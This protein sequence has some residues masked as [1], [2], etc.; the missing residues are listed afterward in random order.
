MKIEK[1]IN[2]TVATTVPT[3]PKIKRRQLVEWEKQRQIYEFTYYN[4]FGFH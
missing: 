2:N 1:E 4:M 3:V